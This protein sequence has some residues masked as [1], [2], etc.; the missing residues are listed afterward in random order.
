MKKTNY[1]SLLAIMMVAVLSIGFTSCGDDDEEVTPSEQQKPE[2]EAP[3]PDRYKSMVTKEWYWITENKDTI[4][5]HYM[6]INTSGY[7]YI[8]NYH[9]GAS[10]NFKTVY[11][12]TEL[13]KYTIAGDTL[14]FACTSRKWEVNYVEVA[15]STDMVKTTIIFSPE[16]ITDF[17]RLNCTFPGTD[18]AAESFLVW[19][20][21]NRGT[22]LETVRDKYQDK[23]QILREQWIGRWRPTTTM[24]EYYKNGNSTTYVDLLPQHELTLSDDGVMTLKVSSEDNPYL[25]EDVFL[26]TTFEIKDGKIKFDL[27]DHD[28]L[29]MQVNSLEGNELDVELTWRT[30]SGVSTYQPQ[31]VSGVFYK[32][33]N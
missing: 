7:Y 9:L 15:S 16:D 18:R 12:D 19:S 26:T 8:Y 1:W 20:K 6:E 31:K 4:D 30:K 22:Y 10:D 21:G 2:D 5:L 29:T 14:V 32:T 28:L 25:N 11:K 33:A 24:I 13:G 23:D 27:Y 3:K 17:G